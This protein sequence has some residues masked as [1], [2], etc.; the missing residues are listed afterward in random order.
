MCTWTGGGASRF[1][2]GAGGRPDACLMTLSCWTIAGVSTGNASTPGEIRDRSAGRAGV[3]RAGDSAREPDGRHDGGASGAGVSGSPST[4]LADRWLSSIRGVSRVCGN[5]LAEARGRVVPTST[6]AVDV[7]R[8]GGGGTSVLGV[9]GGDARR[10]SEDGSGLDLDS[11]APSGLSPRSCS[12]ATASSVRGRVGE[13]CAGGGGHGLSTSG[14][15]G[16]AV[17][18]C[19][20]GGAATGASSA[21][22]PSGHVAC[23]TPGSAAR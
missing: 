4:A 21:C 23:G 20:V 15:R 2:D 17:A 11:S 5:T 6:S 18:G 1:S 19:T 14:A 7:G 10:R 22:W 12:V 3:G 16:G 9:A 8:G 13:G